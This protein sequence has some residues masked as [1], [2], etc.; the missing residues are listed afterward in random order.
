MK[1]CPSCRRPIR[2][3][4]PCPLSPGELQAVRGLSR[5]LKYKEIASEVGLSP[6]TIRSQLVQVYKKL[7]VHDRGHAV[8]IAAMR[9]WL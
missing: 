2:D 9:G 4:Q 1:V 8:I 3:P 7:D 6:S 5:G